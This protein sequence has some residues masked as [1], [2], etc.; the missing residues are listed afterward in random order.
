M[1]LVTAMAMVTA[2]GIMEVM[3]MVAVKARFGRNNDDG[4]G[5]T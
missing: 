5:N 1:V 2:T 4:H 3:V